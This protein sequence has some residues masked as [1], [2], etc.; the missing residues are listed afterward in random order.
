MKD[1]ILKRL[2]N[3]LKIKNNALESKAKF[4]LNITH[5]SKEQEEKEV[6]YFEEGI[7]DVELLE[8]EIE[9]FTNFKVTKFR[10]MIPEK[11]ADVV[12]TFE[13]L[14]NPNALFSLR[15][16][17]IPWLKEGNIPEVVLE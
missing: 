15:E 4:L 9:W 6:K 17:V 13:D 2:G 16:L 14:I 3:E 7:K 12:F 11:N 8:E 10:A 1:R 5:M